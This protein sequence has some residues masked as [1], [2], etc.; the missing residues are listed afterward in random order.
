MRWHGVTLL[1]AWLGL[2]AP[3]GAE[4]LIAIS[5][6]QQAMTVSING[7][8]TYNWAVSTGVPGRD[9]PSGRYIAERLAKVYYSKKFDDAPMPNSVFFHEGYA[10]HGTNE[11]ARHG[12]PASHGCVR[13][14]RANAVTLY[15]LV[16][17]QG[18]RNVRVMIANEP[19]P[20][21]REAPMASE[22]P[23]VKFADASPP[24]DEESRR[25]QQYD[26]RLSPLNE[27][28]RDPLAEPRGY[29]N[30]SP[31]L[32]LRAEPRY[33]P[34]ERPRYRPRDDR[35][36]DTRRDERPPLRR[37]EVRRHEPRY[38]PRRGPRYE[39][40]RESRYDLR[41]EPRRAPRYEPRH[42]PRYESRYDAHRRAAASNC[43]GN[44]SATPGARPRSNANLARRRARNPA[45]AI[46]TPTAFASN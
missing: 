32:P 41:N 20:S 5:K 16:S 34:R 29:P 6:A 45:R 25:E 8:P 7:A 13:L 26:P 42:E 44:M 10:I 21:G 30:M 2:P 28:H 35:R 24:R 14:S 18:L 9:T 39:P 12:T 19:T 37:H 22:R 3:A 11:E 33:D 23:V 38:E 15:N 36:Y 17:A 46:A 40:H 4:V 43:C 31:H 1:S 27:P